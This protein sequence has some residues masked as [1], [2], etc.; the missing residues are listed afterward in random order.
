MASM[1]GLEPGPH[2]WEVSTLTTAPPLLLPHCKCNSTY[3]EMAVLCPF[4][5]L[6]YIRV[7]V[8]YTCIFLPS[9]PVHMLNST[10]NLPVVGIL[11]SVAHDCMCNSADTKV[12]FLCLC[13]TLPY[14]EVGT[15]WHMEKSPS[16][17]VIFQNK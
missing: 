2:W 15:L 16:D 11:Y 4:T 13:T 12:L 7:L 3:L 17:M 10:F 8:L 1:P 6:S 9:L 5:T 14:R